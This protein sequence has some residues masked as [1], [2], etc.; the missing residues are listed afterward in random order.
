MNINNRISF[1]LYI[2]FNGASTGPFPVFSVK[3]KGCEEEPDSNHFPKVYFQVTFWLPL[4]SLLLKLPNESELEQVG[5]GQIIHLP[6]QTPWGL[7]ARVSAGK[8]WDLIKE[9]KMIKN[10]EYIFLEHSDA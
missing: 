8:G 4:P 6:K 1:I 5:K 3:N 2:Y 10:D 7:E 9:E